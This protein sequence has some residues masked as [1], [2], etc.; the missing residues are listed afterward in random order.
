MNKY[1]GNFPSKF[2]SQRKVEKIFM[3]EISLFTWNVC[4]V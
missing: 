4:E 3:I 1:F 2:P